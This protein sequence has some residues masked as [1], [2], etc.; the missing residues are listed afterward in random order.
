MTDE[1]IMLRIF[2]PVLS[3]K[4]KLVIRCIM[5]GLVILAMY[6]NGPMP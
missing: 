6:M 3:W 2:P 1:E 5:I 4:R